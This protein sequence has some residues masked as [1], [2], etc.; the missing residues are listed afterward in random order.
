MTSQ[1]PQGS[2]PEWQQ[3][4]PQWQSQPPQW[5]PT[6]AP[7]QKRGRAKTV[8]GLVVIGV[9]VLIAL[10]AVLQRRP[11]PPTGAAASPSPATQTSGAIPTPAPSATQLTP[12]PTAVGSQQPGSTPPSTFGTDYSVGDRVQVGDEQFITL[13]EFEADWKSDNQF[14]KPDQGNM[15]VA[16]LVEFEGI[17]PEGSSY[18]P[19]Y[20]SLI[21][22]Q[23]FEYNFSAFGREPSIKSSNELRPGEKA[24]GWIT[25]EIPKTADTGTLVYEPGFGLVGD[26]VRYSVE[27]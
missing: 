2:P 1:P 7:N 22:D 13:A 9:V 11:S 24:R 14:I 16:F 18:N 23:A 17:N 19:F 8:V 21:D 6:P 26:E 3:Q 20:F 15:F 25:F 12:L 27:F 4:P 10:A 5:Q